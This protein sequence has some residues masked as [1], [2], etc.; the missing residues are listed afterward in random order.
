MNMLQAKTKTV[1][2][3]FVAIHGEKLI[4]NVF[5]GYT[6]Y[7]KAGEE[8]RRISISIVPGRLSVKYAEGGD[9]AGKVKTSHRK[10]GRIDTGAAFMD[11]VTG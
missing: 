3:C 8:G 7:M 6:S 4:A 11:D 2:A 10:C 1:F 9:A 5:P